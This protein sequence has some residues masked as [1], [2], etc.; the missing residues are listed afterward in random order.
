M[1]N[2][3][4]FYITDGSGPFYITGRGT[5]GVQGSAN[6]SVLI[7]WGFNASRCSNRYGD[8]TEIN[9]LYNS[10]KYVIRY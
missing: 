3:N 4:T 6:Y 7:S 10:C 1:S 2:I 5:D 8:Y 9:P